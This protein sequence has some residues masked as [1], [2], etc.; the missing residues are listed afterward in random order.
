MEVRM[1]GAPKAD[2]ILL[3][4]AMADGGRPRPRINTPT[5]PT[6]RKL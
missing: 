4:C 6:P 3:I 1:E 5:T 2:E